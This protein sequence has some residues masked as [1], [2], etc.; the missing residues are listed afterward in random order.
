[1]TRRS[2]AKFGLAAMLL[3]LAA[4]PAR[5]NLVTVNQVDGVNFSYT[6]VDT[7]NT[8]VVT[9]D[10][11]SLVTKIN[12]SVISP[13][14]AATFAQLTL[15]P[16]VT[17]DITPGLSSQFFPNFTPNTPG[18]PGYGI[19]DLTSASVLFDYG[20]TSGLVNGDGL[21]MTGAVALDPTGATT[22]TQGSTTYD[23]SNFNNFTFF[24]LSLGTQ[25]ATGTLIYNTLLAGNGTF[26]GTG[27][28]DQ[29]VATVPEPSSVLLLGIGGIVTVLGR[30]RRK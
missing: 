29:F 23:F 21:T 16:V 17:T 26:S 24:T 10:P 20:I 1:M 6:A 11:S 13:T 8:L 19:S 14:L 28:F 4:L 27:Q 12:G 7:N 9:F 3:G 5:A 22:F 25:D 30:R 2:L 15:S 18:L